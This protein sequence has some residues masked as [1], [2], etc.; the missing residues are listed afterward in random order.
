MN[1]KLMGALALAALA[2][3][4]S[5]DISLGAPN[6][7]ASYQLGQP[8]FGTRAV[9]PGAT[10][11]DVTTFSGQGYAAG[12]GA[13]VG[14]LATAKY[15]SEEIHM[16]AAQPGVIQFTFSIANFNATAVTARP[17]VRFHQLDN[18]GGTN[19]GTYITGFSFVPFSIPTGVSLWSATT[20]AFALPQNFSMGITFDNSTVPATTQAQINALGVGIFNPPDVGSSPDLAFQTTAASV[21]NVTG[22]AGGTFNFSGNPVANFGW[23]IVP[24][25]S[26]MAL[27]GLGGLIAGRRRRA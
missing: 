12:G 15:V 27:L 14:G 13:A 6:M 9:T 23:E 7:V 11:S 19:T 3:T 18:A 5:A 24:A 1:S 16:I 22:A 17:R 8:A 2:G 26:S 10:Y 4:A 21:G 20:A 25:P